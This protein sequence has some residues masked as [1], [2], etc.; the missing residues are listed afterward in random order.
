L[1]I[2][3]IKGNQVVTSYTRWLESVPVWANFRQRALETAIAEITKRTD[4]HVEIKSL[5]RSKHRRVTSV[6]LRLRSKGAGRWLN[7][8]NQAPPLPF[9]RLTP[10]SRC[11]LTLRVWIDN[12]L[13]VRWL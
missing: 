9:V 5:V 7:L 2:E 11:S 8:R 12:F 1:R 3:E 13:R 6:T 10:S 4:L